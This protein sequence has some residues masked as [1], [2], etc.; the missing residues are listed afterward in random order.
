MPVQSKKVVGRRTLHFDSYDELLGDV[1]KLA[2]EPHRQL[3]NW[4][5]G[6]ACQHLAKTMDLSMDGAQSAAPW[7]LRIVGR[8]L[9]KRYLSRT[10]PAG[11]TAP[12]QSGLLPD[13]SASAAGVAALEHAVGRLQQTV[14]RHPHPIFGPLTRAEWDQLHM[15]HS[16]LHLSFF[17]PEA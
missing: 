13:P 15:R 11:F 5:L 16:E 14:E 4:S 7:P 1:R 2:A 10:L 6:E 12:P 8:L 3:G 17:V 9:K